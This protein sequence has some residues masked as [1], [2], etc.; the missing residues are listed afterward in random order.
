MFECVARQ[1]A[2][3][4]PAAS[5]AAHFV[6]VGGKHVHV[7]SKVWNIVSNV[8]WTPPIWREFYLQSLLAAVVGSDKGGSKAE[9]EGYEFHRE[10]GFQ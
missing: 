2:V 6:A 8:I 3:S 9:K 7:D 4:V 1:T 10:T 5:R